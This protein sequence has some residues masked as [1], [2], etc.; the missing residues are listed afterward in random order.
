MSCC[1]NKR[2]AWQRNEHVHSHNNEVSFGYK[3]IREDISFEY[4]GTIAISITGSV[5]GKKYR[6]LFNGDRQVIDYRDAAG[7]MGEPYLRKNKPMRRWAD[8]QQLPTQWRLLRLLLPSSP[9][10]HYPGNLFF[11]LLDFERNLAMVGM[12]G[13][14]QSRDSPACI[15]SILNY[16][17]RDLT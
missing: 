10:F 13:M 9:S 6:F 2:A 12:E 11:Q 16:L 4:T 15:A 1:G 17:C 5:S 3:K 7:M 8:F 14:A